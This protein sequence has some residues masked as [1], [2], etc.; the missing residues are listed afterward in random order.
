VKTFCTICKSGPHGGPERPAYAT[1]H[2]VR[3]AVR[4]RQLDPD[5]GVLDVVHGHGR[6]LR[7]AATSITAL[8]R[9]RHTV[10]TVSESL[11]ADTGVGR[12]GQTIKVISR[13]SALMM[14]LN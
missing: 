14:T 5:V 3:V 2:G 8:L 12:F 13:S 6:Y 9:M 4:P 11:R 1:G 7:R 10:A